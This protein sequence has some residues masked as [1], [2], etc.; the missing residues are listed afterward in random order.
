MFETMTRMGSSGVTEA[1][2][3]DRSLRFEGLKGGTA[4]GQLDR[5]IQAGGN[6]LKWTFAVW[7]KITQ[8]GTVSGNST[9][10]FIG[11][12]RG[13]D[14]SNESVM[15]LDSSDRFYM[16]DSSNSRCSLISDRRFRDPSAWMHLVVAVDTTQGTAANRI[17]VYFNGIQETEWTTETYPD[18][19]EEMGWNKEQLHAIGRYAYPGPTSGANTRWHGYMADMYWIDNQQLTPT[20]FGKTDPD[21]GE[22]IPIEYQGTY[23]T[24]GFYLDF[25]DNSDTTSSTLGKDRSGNDNDW[26]PAN[27]SVAAGTGCDSMTDTP[28]NNFCTLNNIEG[29]YGTATY[30]NASLEVSASAAWVPMRGTMAVTSGKYYW[31]V[32]GADGNTF[33]GVAPINTDLI[34]INP[35]LRD[36]VIVYYGSDGK[37]RIDGTF[38]TY[39]NAYG[40]T[41]VIGVALDVDNGKLYFAEDNTWQDSGDPTSGASGT[42]AISLSAATGLVGNPIIPFFCKNGT[43]FQVN[44]GQRAFTHTPPTGYQTLCAANL[45]EPTI[46]NGSDFFKTILYTGNDSD[47]RDITGVGFQPD[48]LHLSNRDGADW[49]FIQDSVRGANKALF[50]NNANAEST[51]NDNG[52]VNSFNADGFNVTAGDSGNTNE[53][54]EDYVAWNWKAGTSFS[55]DASATSIGTIDSSGSVNHTSG[56]S[57]VSYTGSGSSGTIKHGLN[58]EPEVIIVKNRDV[59]DGWQMYHH[60]V[61]ATHTAQMDGAGIF[62]D[63]DAVWNDTAPNGSVFSVNNDDKSNASTEKYIAYVFSEVE[64]Y[65][66]FGTYEGGGST[67]GPFVYTGFR[68]AYLLLKRTETTPNAY[69]NIFDSARDPYNSGVTADFKRLLWHSEGAEATNHANYT[70]PDLL[71]NGFKLR[72]GGADKNYAG[73]TFIFLAF[74]E[75]PFKYA[76]AR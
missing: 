20:S 42:G 71:S 1:Y 40:N 66:K 65:S 75:C 18:E 10:H 46:K 52:H 5:D 33:I 35:M 74:A 48:L 17:K 68:P 2:E 41:N 39:G 25:S 27:F 22:F 9:K 24:T 31:E 26:T 70:P 29:G 38:T 34:T 54:N 44:F 60:V 62:E 12:Y 7:F 58:V 76:N 6:A 14:G 61:G 50:T 15:G 32:Y 47:D 56:L 30:N 63:T 4:A 64:G 21:T 49:R 8:Q 59:E 55:N 69:W 23:G 36:G 53:N 57:I 37:K 16:Q 28:T 45:P 67:D 43:Q 73:K 3:I 51:D 11:P 13:G 72:H 19:D